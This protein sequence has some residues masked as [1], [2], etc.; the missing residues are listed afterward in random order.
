VKPGELVALVGENGS[1]KSTLLKLALRLYE[2]QGGQLR[3]EGRD[4]REWDPAALRRRFALVLQEFVRYKLTAG[5]NVGV[6][7]APRIDDGAAIVAAAVRGQADPFLSKL[8][9]GY[10]TQL[11][12]WFK[13]GQELSGGQWQ[14]VA[15]S[16]AFMR[17]DATVLVLDEPSASLDPEAEAQ[18]FAQVRAATRDGREMVL[19]VSHRFGTVRT[20]DR[21]VV[22]D[23]GRVIEEGSHDELLARGGRYAQLYRLQAA[24][25]R[26]E[27]DAGA[28]AAR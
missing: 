9:E 10:R 16:R 18:L 12:K 14:K 24:G 15:L 7:D 28:P 3:L 5:E 20:A 19:L 2:P 21:I 11:G 8:P 6:G 23:A 13:G 25:Y 4:V 26:D 27:P 22:L 17:N 1:G